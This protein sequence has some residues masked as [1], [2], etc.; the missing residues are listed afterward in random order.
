MVTPQHSAALLGLDGT[1]G[2]TA[3]GSLEDG[4]APGPSHRPQLSQNQF[5][6]AIK[7]EHHDAHRPVPHP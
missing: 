6:R 4:A 1:D 3:Q 7:A 5:L 2:R